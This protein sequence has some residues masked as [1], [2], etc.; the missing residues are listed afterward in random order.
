MSVFVRALG[1]VSLLSL[2][3]APLA[4]QGA[5]PKFAYVNSS[6][7]MASAPGRAP[8]DSQLQKEVTVLQDSVKK[9]NDELM[10]KYAAF[11]K[12]GPTLTDKQKEVKV[13]ELQDGQAAMQTKQQ[14]FEERMQRRQAEL[15]QPLLDQIKLVLED[16]R[17]EGGYTFIF[18]VASGGAG[19]VAADKNL[20][21]SDRVS[22]KLRT[23]PI[24]TMAKG[25]GSKATDKKPSI[26]A[27]MSAPTGVKPPAA[28]APPK[29]PAGE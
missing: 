13:K 14:E 1:A 7:V 12:S 25:D 17:V 24:P 28:G 21:I 26:G 16:L 6:Q 5:A 3:A 22:A 10:A 9:M 15:V 29:K 23:M 18:D 2:I 11:Q 19:I 20:D 4:A 27:P 8:I